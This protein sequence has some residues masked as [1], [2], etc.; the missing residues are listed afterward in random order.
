M[1]C[2]NSGTGKKALILSGYI[3]CSINRNFHLEISVRSYS[4]YFKLLSELLTMSKSVRWEYES[5]AWDDMEAEHMALLYKCETHCL[6]RAK[7]PH[8]YLNWKKKYPFLFIS[9]TGSNDREN[10]HHKEDFIQKL[11][12]WKAFFFFFAEQSNLNKS[13]QSLQINTLTQN[14]NINA[15]MKKS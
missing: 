9:D 15:F 14:D 3:V 12:M 10:L 5:F 4:L 2:R 13:L 6:S 8:G 1:N 7:V 11:G